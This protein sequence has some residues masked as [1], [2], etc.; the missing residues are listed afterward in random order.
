MITKETKNDIKELKIIELSKR[1]SFLKQTFQFFEPNATQCCW[2]V[3]WMDGARNNLRRLNPPHQ[4][5][6]GGIGFLH[7][8]IS[9]PIL[10]TTNNDT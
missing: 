7:A 3:P 5:L 2:S 8:R 4:F 9:L 10:I 6:M 1:P